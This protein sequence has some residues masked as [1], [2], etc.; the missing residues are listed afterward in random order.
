MSS[1]TPGGIVHAFLRQRTR[2]ISLTGFSLLLMCVASSL[3]GATLVATRWRSAL[4]PFQSYAALGLE[5]RYAGA[6]GEGT[7][8]QLVATGER[9]WTAVLPAWA[10]PTLG[11]SLWVSRGPLALRADVAALGLERWGDRGPVGE[12]S[13]YAVATFGAGSP[14]REV[15]VQDRKALAV[16]GS[17]GPFV[18][19]ARFKADFDGRPLTAQGFRERVEVEGRWGR[20]GGAITATLE[21]RV[22]EREPVR[23]GY[24]IRQRVRF[25]FD[26]RVAA[27]IEHESS[28]NLF[29][30]VTGRAAPLQVADLRTSR[31]GVFVEA[32][33]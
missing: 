13:C 2:A 25:F 30:E 5:A 16:T 19:L 3:E 28:G 24:A 10:V 27:G 20:L 31:L 4:D 15:S 29:D 32:R 14:M 1:A 8:W 6:F 22:H 17:V 11:G 21:H 33:W 9:Q 26:D 18:R 7:G 12:V 23:T